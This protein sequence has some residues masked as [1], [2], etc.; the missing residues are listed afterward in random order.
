MK[1]LTLLLF[2]VLAIVSLASCGFTRA[3]LPE[4][5]V[6][7]M[8]REAGELKGTASIKVQTDGNTNKFG[9]SPSFD[10]AYSPINKLGLIGAFRHTKRNVREEFHSLWSKSEQTDFIYLGDRVS[11]GAGYY[12]PITYA[13]Q[14]DIYAG[15]VWG[16][17]DRYKTNTDTLSFKYNFYQLFLQPSWGY[18]VRDIFDVA[19]GLKFTY[20]VP[21]NFQA[22]DTELKYELTEPGADIA[23]NNYFLL[24][25]FVNC[26]VGGDH[27]KFSAQVGANFGI[28]KPTMRAG[29]FPFYVSLGA[30]LQLAPRMRK[31][32]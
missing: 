12:E 24:D 18:H 8:L 17:L 7:P 15:M 28:S 26:N 27:I 22:A 21:T 9:V 25:P 20:Q 32:S 2:P 19:I 10:I 14:V 6:M 3:Y 31:N 5:T 13:T 23:K 30:T 29:K 11:L 1:T 4:R 16:N